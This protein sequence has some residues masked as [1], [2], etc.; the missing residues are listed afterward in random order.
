MELKR[1]AANSPVMIEP[2]AVEEVMRSPVRTVKPTATVR[3]AATRLFEEQIGSLVVC[4]NGSPV[5]ILTDV[6]VS[7][8]VSEGKDTETT[9]VEDVMGQPLVTVDADAPIEDAADLVREHT[10]KR[11][12]VLDNGGVAGIV[13]TTDLAMYLP[14]LVRMGRE[15]EPDETRERR[16]IR[17]DTAYERDDWEFEYLGNEAQIDVG[18]TVRFSKVISEE[19]VEA[20][21]EASGD[22]NRLHMDEEFAAASRFGERIA[23][24]TLVV[25]IVSSALARLPGMVIYLSQE[26]SYL[27]PVPLGEEVTTECEVVEHIGKNRFRLSTTVDR[28]DGETVIDGEAAVIADAIPTE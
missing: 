28:S 26:V 23:H 4:E 22:T 12:P 15:Q 21:A 11:L 7:Q 20:F 25:G 27:G 3:E 9:A 19:D 16:S 14:H 10:I 8:V 2:I 5:G 13:T 6:D 1:P 24:G 17:V 18:D